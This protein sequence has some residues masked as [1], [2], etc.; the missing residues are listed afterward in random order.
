M[1][2]QHSSYFPVSFINETG[3]FC[4]DGCTAQFPSRY[5]FIMLTP[6]FLGKYVRW[7]YNEAHHGRGHMDSIGGTV[8]HTIL[9]KV[10]S[11]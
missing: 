9:K 1:E 10:K 8:K 11:G 2:N 3:D 4:C 6:M 5:I 7:Y